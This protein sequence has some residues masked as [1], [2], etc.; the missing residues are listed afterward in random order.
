[1]RLTYLRSG[2]SLNVMNLPFKSTSF[3]SDTPARVLGHTALT[4][5]LK[6]LLPQCGSELRSLSFDH[7][8][9]YTQLAH[10]HFD[11]IVRY[12]PNLEEFLFGRVCKSQL[13]TDRINPEKLTLQ[14]AQ[15]TQLRTVKL[16]DYLGRNNLTRRRVVDLLTKISHLLSN[17]PLRRLTLVDFRFHLVIGTRH[18]TQLELFDSRVNDV[19]MVYICRTSPNLV[20]LKIINC[21]PVQDFSP[22]AKLKKLETLWLG[23]SITSDQLESICQKCGKINDI[24][25]EK[26]TDFTSFTWLRHI[27]GL[28][29]LAVSTAELTD[30]AVE[31]LPE[32]LVLGNLEDLWISNFRANNNVSLTE[33]GLVRLTR[34][35]PQ[36]KILHVEGHRMTDICV[37]AI[38]RNCENLRKISFLACNITNESLRILGECGNLRLLKFDRCE[39]IT[40]EG[41]WHLNYVRME[42]EITAPMRVEIGSNHQIWKSPLVTEGILKKANVQ[43]GVAEWSE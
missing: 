39:L 25:V 2:R 27:N 19:Q 37:S 24:N 16:T 18:L 31:E 12:C 9:Y 36:L 15:L 28:K 43:L 17:W 6:C 22:I 8:H 5:V 14:L 29:E 1:M 23:C 35:C 3:L 21:E 30:S 38:M 4:A 20:D 33:S 7:S 41:F 34:K 10:N 40:N 11:L 13:V 26:A 42:K 32:D